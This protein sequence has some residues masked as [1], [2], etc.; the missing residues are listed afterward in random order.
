MNDAYIDWI[1]ADLRTPIWWRSG[2]DVNELQPSLEALLAG[3][4]ADP[5]PQETMP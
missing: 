2:C 5:D 1:E 4:P 3:Y